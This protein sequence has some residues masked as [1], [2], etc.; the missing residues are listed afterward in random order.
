[1]INNTI[2][3]ILP[4]YVNDV[5]PYENKNELPKEGEIEKI[6]ITMDDGKLY[7]WSNEYIPLFEATTCTDANCYTYSCSE[8]E[9]QQQK[10]IKIEECPCCGSRK[11]KIKDSYYQCEYCDSM[12]SYE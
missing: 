5:V 11:F 8:G 10:R 4:N 12:F 7:R 1:M 9:I 3:L 2:D 6:Y